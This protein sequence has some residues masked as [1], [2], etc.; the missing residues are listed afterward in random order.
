MVETLL[1]IQI[2][3]ICFAAFMLYVAFLHFKKGNISQLE[4]V[5]WLTV[6]TAFIFFTLNPRV[7]DPILAELFVTRA[8]D[9]LMISAFMI[10][11][12]LGFTNHVGIKTLQREMRR[13][14]SESAKKN[15]KK[16]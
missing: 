16:T 1:G 14:V 7:L 8:M 6:W 15:A 2:I 13:L 10:L 9:L 5:F 12:Y 3:A 11:G 4:F